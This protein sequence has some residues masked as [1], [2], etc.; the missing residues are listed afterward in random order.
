MITFPPFMP[1][2]WVWEAPQSG[3]V[4]F[5]TKGKTSIPYCIGKIKKKCAKAVCI[6]HRDVGV[7]D[8][9]E[10]LIRCESISPITGGSLKQ[11]KF[12][13]FDNQYNRVINGIPNGVKR[14]FA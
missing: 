10:F 6:P 14:E 11:L 7:L 2:Q 1:V 13:I 12:A 3:G 8:L 4:F 5:P 9:K